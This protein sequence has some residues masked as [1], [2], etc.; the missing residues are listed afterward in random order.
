[1][2]ST[3][4]TETS[5]GEW[6]GG[7]IEARVVGAKVRIAEIEVAILQIGTRLIEEAEGYVCEV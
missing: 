3:T 7:D 1:M 2:A 4:D 6:M 5:F